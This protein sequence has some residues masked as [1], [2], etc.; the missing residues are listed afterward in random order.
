MEVCPVEGAIELHHSLM[1]QVQWIE[2]S[3]IKKN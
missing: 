2:K 3:E 1:N